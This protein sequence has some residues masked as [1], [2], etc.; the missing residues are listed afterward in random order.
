MHNNVLHVHSW[1]TCFSETPN[2]RKMILLRVYMIK[3]CQPH[4]NNVSGK[5]DHRY[6]L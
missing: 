2:C 4:T 3:K 5:G 1:S 6:G